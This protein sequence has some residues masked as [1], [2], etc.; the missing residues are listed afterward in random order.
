MS[1]PG[2]LARP[3]AEEPWLS[4]RP[5]KLRRRPG[6]LRPFGTA[7]VAALVGGGVLAAGGAHTA[8]LAP[9]VEVRG[10]G[11][12][13]IRFFDDPVVRE[14]LL[15]HNM[16]VVASDLGSRQSAVALEN[17]LAAD[18]ASVDFVLTSAQAAAEQ[19]K[20][21]LAAR[22]EPPPHSRK[23][24]TSPL[25]FGSYR[26]YAE[27]LEVNGLAVRRP[28]PEG[29][30]YTVDL[31]AFLDLGIRRTTWADLGKH[32]AARTGSG[33][34]VPPGKVVLAQT[35]D[36]CVSSGGATFLGLVAWQLNNRAV[37]QTPAQADR[38]AAVVAPL[39]LAQGQPLTSPFEQYISPQGPDIA[40]IVYLYEHQYL[41]YQASRGTP[42]DD[43]V[44]LYTDAIASSEPDFIARTE[45]GRALAD[46]LA[47]EDT[48]LRRR[49][50]ELGYR[51]FDD[52]GDDLDRWLAERTGGV[53]ARYQGPMTV[54]PMPAAALMER[55]IDRVGGC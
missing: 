23:V 45:A 17:A 33:S 2:V 13:T 34:A 40:P 22:G 37:V 47:R 24:F 30:Y 35:T 1:D 55:M 42:D 20:D 39:L 10:L 16:R 9:V 11:G 18:P 25:V 31:A 5:T 54:A 32:P 29:H 43:L 49:A 27:L 46:L 28:G 12:A 8:P 19:V 38:A 53:L 41:R 14:I 26:A 50:T 52:P 6:F 48:G 7:L 51:V 36:M 4:V 21:L 44:L 15:R 3:V